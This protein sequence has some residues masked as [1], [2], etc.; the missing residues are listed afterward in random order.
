MIVKGV[1]LI[2]IG[3]LSYAF[4][5][6][7]VVVVETNVN[8]SRQGWLKVMVVVASFVGAFAYDEVG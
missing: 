8:G 4:A 5:V 6:G 3:V 7:L 1:T 2:F